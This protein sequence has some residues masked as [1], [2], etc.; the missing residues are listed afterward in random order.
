M[1]HALRYLIAFAAC[2]SLQAQVTFQRG[3]TLSQLINNLYGGNGIQLAVN[4]HDAHFGTNN[5]FQD[6]TKNLQATLQSRTFFPI[7][8]AV[9]LVSFRFNEA[10]GTYERVE[11]SLGPILAERGSTSGKGNLN[12]STTYTF[13]EYQTIAGKDTTRLILHHCL[14]DACTFGDPTFP[15]LK[16][17]ID[18]DLHFRLKSQAIALSVVYGLTNRV[19]LGIVLP[20]IRND[21]QVFTHGFIV[22][23][24]G[25]SATIHRFDPAVE[26]P[27]QYGTGTAIGIGDIVLRG[28]MRLNVKGGTDSALL[29][30]VTLPTGDRDNF[31]GS[32]HVKLRE[33]FI[34][35]KPIRRFTPHLNLAYEATFGETKLNAFDY[36]FGSE[37][38]ATERVTISTDVIGVVR[39]RA[40]GLF[41]SE[42]LGDQSLLS[43]SEVDGVLGAKMKIGNDRA[44]LMN[45]LMP[46]NSTGIRPSYVVTIGVQMTM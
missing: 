4:G 28:K 5:D 20:Y 2:T 39:P 38:A 37:I 21:L 12:I 46:M 1:R 32:G 36:R 16:D 23:A 11:G 31:L 30:D 40:T 15:F 6:F 9:G 29:T 27:D 33:T 41:R 8:S 26:T 43:R 18:V 19:D 10:T 24:P 45:L 42:A 22:V 14:T 25:S 34:L 7:P 13:A 3:A 35:S 44:F 17:T